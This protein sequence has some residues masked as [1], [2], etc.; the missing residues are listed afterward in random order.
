MDTQA[1]ADRLKLPAMKVA[2]NA[3][4][5]YSN[6]PVGAA[7]YVS[8]GRIFTGCNVENAALGLTQCAE[9]SAISAAIAAGVE[10]ESLTALLIYTPGKQPHSPCGACRQVMHELMAEDSLVIASCDTNETMTWTKAQ[11]LPEAF[12][13]ESLLPELTPGKA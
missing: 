10:R 11:Y 7:L 5:P 3:Y 6:F 1:L 12:T 13:A 9:R 8:D 4:A 2:K